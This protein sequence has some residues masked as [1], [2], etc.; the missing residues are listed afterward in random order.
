MQNGNERPGS[1]YGLP[2][3]SPLLP[4]VVLI[5]G[6]LVALGL[7]RLVST[8]RNQVGLP[9]YRPIQI[10]LLLVLEGLNYIENLFRLL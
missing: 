9:A 4:L 10:L 5:V 6:G 1:N 2:S 8:N 7:Y 3:S